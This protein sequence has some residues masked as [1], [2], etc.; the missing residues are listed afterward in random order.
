M[1]PRDSE[2]ARLADLMTHAGLQHRLLDFN[3]NP[4][5]SFLAASPECEAGCQFFVEAPDGW[6]RVTSPL[7]LDGAPSLALLQRL[8]RVQVDGGFGHA[9]IARGQVRLSVALPGLPGLGSAVI[10]AIQRIHELRAVVTS[11]RPLPRFL[12]TVGPGDPIATLAQVVLA[13]GARVPLTWAPGDEFHGRMRDPAGLECEL[14]LWSPWP[15]VFTIEATRAPAWPCTTDEPTLRAIHRINGN[16]LAGELTP[17]DGA[18]RYRWSCPYIW[19]DVPHVAEV[20]LPTIV[21]SWRTA[22][23]LS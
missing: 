6:V 7:A 15:D 1:T 2:A 20:V 4:V 16:V 19:L 18:L 12:A 5:A 21:D 10:A 14:R 3:G 17:I 23:R 22:A 13:V 8:A 11:T 9:A